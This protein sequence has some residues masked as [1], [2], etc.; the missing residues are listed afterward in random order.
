MALKSK[1]FGGN[2][3]CQECAVVDAKHILTGDS[4]LHVFLDDSRPGPPSER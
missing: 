4:G 2:Q 1:W 3:R